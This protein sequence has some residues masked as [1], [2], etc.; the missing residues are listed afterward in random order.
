[1]V[2]L[3]IA[4]AVLLTAV[5][6]SYT[7][8]G[9][10]GVSMVVYVMSEGCHR[11]SGATFRNS[12]TKHIIIITNR[13]LIIII[14]AAIIVR[15]SYNRLVGVAAGIV[16]PAL[17]ESWGA[18]QSNVYI[19]L[20]LFVWLFVSGLACALTLTPILIG[21][22]R[23]CLFLRCGVRC[24]ITIAIS[25]AWCTLGVALARSMPTQVSSQASP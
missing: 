20:G 5:V 25:Q 2:A 18:C 8:R 21:A 12:N 22:V 11:S 16:W 6:S 10:G 7:G 23:V 4:I 3:K 1:M 15:K 19:A 24:N 13:R 14:T 9:S 17:L